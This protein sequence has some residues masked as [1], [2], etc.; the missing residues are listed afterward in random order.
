MLRRYYRTRRKLA[1]SSNQ[2]SLTGSVDEIR[3]RMITG[4]AYDIRRPEQP[5][6]LRCRVNEMEARIDVADRYRRDSVIHGHPTGL[7]GFEF[8]VPDEI[9]AIESISVRFL[10]NGSAIPLRSGVL[11]DEQ[12]NRALPCEWRSDNGFRLP[13]AFLIG[14]SKCGTS[15]LYTHLEQH[16]DLCVSKPKEPMYFE[17]EFDRGAAYYFNR[18]FSHWRGQRVVVDARVGHL[19]LPYIPKRLFEYNRDARLLVLLRNPAERA[20]SSWWHW[21]SRGLESLSFKEAVA[22]DLER[23]R[24]GYR[25]ARPKEQALHERTSSESGRG[26]FRTYVDAGY[27]HEQLCRYLEFFP[28]EQLRVMLLDDLARDPQSVVMETLDFLGARRDPAAH[29]LYPVINRS[30]PDMQNHVDA[31]TLSWL[32]EHYRPHNEKLGQLI[33]RSLRHWDQPF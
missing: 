3:Y 4:W 32:V 23:I 28:R 33:G 27:Y 11:G 19:Y 1:S 8:P 21:Y 30:D 31:A 29:F 16:P 24:A 20:V 5:V 17:A 9:E 26:M 6:F 14:G 10:E 7:A 13:S 15:S 18:Y 22:A 12:T 2:D 25:L